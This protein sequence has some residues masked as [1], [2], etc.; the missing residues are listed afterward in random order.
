LGERVGDLPDVG[1]VR[2]IPVGF[3][4]EVGSRHGKRKATG[5]DTDAVALIE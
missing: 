4:F 1:G 2:G 5:F 3:V